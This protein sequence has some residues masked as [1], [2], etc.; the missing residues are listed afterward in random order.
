MK[1]ILIVLLLLCSTAQAQIDLSF[2][3]AKAL[4]GITN[5]QQVGNR[6]LVGNDSL[7]SISNV[8]IIKATTSSKFLL[9]EANANLE[10][11]V[12]LEKL[13]GRDNEYLLTQPGTYYITA[14]SFDPDKGIDKKRIKVVLDG[15]VPTPPTP[16]TPV[17]PTPDPT[18]TPD[19]VKSFRVIFVKE[20]SVT[21]NAE[22][23][24]IPGA[25]AIRDYLTSKT[26]PEGGFAGWREYDPQQNIMN[27]QPTM[28]ALWMAA[29]SSITKV[30]CVIIEVN[31]KPTIID[32]PK[33]VDETVKLLKAYGG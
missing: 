26:T 32:Y 6:F 27:E 15:T 7:P 23:T 29:K 24:A 13:E 22:Q 30:P 16:P 17:P 25:K 1:T 33:N 31:G 5:P 2:T 21:L 4:V 18:P 3:K 11:V 8:L 20:S 28:K 14:T 12:D 10:E 19:V 9:I